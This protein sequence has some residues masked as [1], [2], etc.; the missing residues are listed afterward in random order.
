[1]K[2]FHLIFILCT[3]LLLLITVGW[4]FLWNYAKQ[5][6]VPQNVYAGGLSIGGMNIEEA[7]GLLEQ[8]KKLLG[9]RS[10]QIDI[11]PVQGLKQEVAKSS[12]WTA[13]QFGY[14][15]EFDEVLKALDQLNRGSIWERA[16]Y[17]YHFPKSFPMTQKWDQYLFETLLRQQWGWMEKDQPVDAKR[18][19]TDDDTVLYEPHKNAFRLNVQEVA[20]QLSVWMIEPLNEDNDEQ[21]KTKNNTSGSKLPPLVNASFHSVLPVEEIEPEVT[22]ESLKELGL[23]RVIMSFSTEFLTSGEGRAYNVTAAASVLH[24]WLLEPDEEF[25]YSTLVKKLEEQFTLKEAP[26]ILNGKFEPG[27]GG[28]ICQVSSTLYQAVLRSGLTIVE[29]RNHSLPVA[30]MPLGH[31]ATYAGDAIDFRFRNSTGKQLLIRT[32][33]ENRKLTVK[34]IGTMPSNERYEIESSTV[35]T[36]SPEVVRTLNPN[37]APGKTVT[38]DAGRQ[39]YVV[40]TY[41]ILLRDGKE[42]SRERVSRDTYRA[43]PV[44]IEYGPNAPVPGNPVQTSRIVTP[45]P[46]ATPSPLNQTRTETNGGLLEDGI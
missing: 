21:A 1:M 17:R 18:I 44:I 30:Y 3:S 2:K 35:K 40:E 13:Q 41:R 27:V 39:G 5:Q 32:H 37:L 45:S 14:E 38:K 11:M 16:E 28:G 24:D 34:L 43:Q 15:A 23:D 6:T 36:V 10:I 12:Q 22:V 19:I 25:A 4:G 26:V 20:Q 8:Y 42:V 9:S 31:D 46:E 29:R 7:K 33:V